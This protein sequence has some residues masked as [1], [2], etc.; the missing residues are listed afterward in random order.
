MPRTRVRPGHVIRDI[1][2]EQIP[3]AYGQGFQS[4]ATPSDLYRTYIALVK[5]ANLEV[6]SRTRQRGMSRHSFTGLLYQAKRL[7]LIVASREEPAVGLPSE[8]RA[9]LLNIDGVR[10]SAAVPIGDR[11]VVEARRLYYAIGGD[12][13]DTSPAWNN[14]AQAY[15]EMIDRER[16]F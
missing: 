1:L 2:T 16:G 15:M 5:E 9:P 6:V 14:I 7:G 12:G 13:A 4:E 3:V 11:Q 8:V 10:T